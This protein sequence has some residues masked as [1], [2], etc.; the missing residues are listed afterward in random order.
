MKPQIVIKKILKLFIVIWI[1]FTPDL[2]FAPPFPT[3][4][5]CTTPVPIDGGIGLLIIA[6]M[7]IG[8]RMT[9]VVLKKKY[10][11]T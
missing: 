5:T 4:P 6:A 10:V 11:S 8:L 3:C 1:L 2:S 7:I 9:I